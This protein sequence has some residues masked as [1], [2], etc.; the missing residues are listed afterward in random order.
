MNTTLQEPN[1]S[2]TPAPVSRP[3]SVTLV[4]FMTDLMRARPGHRPS[5]ASS[6]PVTTQRRSKS[7]RS[8]T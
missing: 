2:A 6:K 8:K 7:K 5:E 1:Q 4:E 3:K